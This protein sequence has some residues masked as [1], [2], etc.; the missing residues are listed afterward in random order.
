MTIFLLLCLSLV[1]ILI[2]KCAIFMI[3]QFF[4][5]NFFLWL[6]WPYMHWKS[7]SEFYSTHFFYWN[8]IKVQQSHLREERGYTLKQIFYVSRHLGLYTFFKFETFA[9]EHTPFELYSL[10]WVQ[11]SAALPPNPMRTKKAKKNITSVLRLTPLN[12]IKIV[13]FNLLLIF[14]DDQ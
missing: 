3:F 8:Y 11:I 13:F 14:I 5:N 6:G 2:L 1:T 9:F 10:S 12:K 4:E 7:C